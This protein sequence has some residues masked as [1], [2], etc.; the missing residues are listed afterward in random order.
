[1][2]HLS[3]GAILA[4]S[5]RE[6]AAH[7]S[8][9]TIPVRQYHCIRQSPYTAAM[10]VF[11][12]LSDA[13]LQTVLEPLSLTLDSARAATHG[14]ENSNYLLRC[15]DQD[16]Q[17]RGLV[18]T[19]FEQRPLAQLPWFAALLHA[20]QD[21][22]LPVPAPIEVAG[23]TILPVAGKA[24]FLVPWL[25]GE[26]VFAPTA[27]HCRA[28]GALLARLHACP[29]P[30]GDA[31]HNERTHLQ[32]LAR[33]HLDALPDTERDAARLTLE[34]WLALRGR[35]C[36]CHADLFRDN[37]LFNGGDVSGLLD[38]YNACAELP[39]YDLAVVANDWCVEEEGQLDPLRLT[40]LLAGYG[41]SE[42]PADLPLALAAAA[43]RFYLSRL[44]AQQQATQHAGAEGQVSKDPEVF[45]QIF[46]ARF[47]AW[48]QSA[49]T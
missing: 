9:I 48:Q 44:H 25:P 37:V 19:L 27:T 7:D 16:G 26:H 46:M 24:A 34:H 41:L 49:A 12:P 6:A 47:N 39:V 33:Q 17:P 29:L 4:V 42:A 23:Q 45:R 43:L 30:D 5:I 38:L 36:L 10:S 8:Q 22:G 40:A 20:L 3:V 18:L 32:A 35:N 13:T 31:P 2:R 21:A 1:M 15:H 11:T 28:V 14:I